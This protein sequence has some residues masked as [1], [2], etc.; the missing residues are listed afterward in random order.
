MYVLYQLFT[1]GKIFLG[2]FKTLDQAKLFKM[3]LTYGMYKIE[4]EG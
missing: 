4:K 3:S 1:N 2:R